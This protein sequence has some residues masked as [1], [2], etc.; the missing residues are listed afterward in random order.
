MHVEK[1]LGKS[2]IIIKG[3]EVLETRQQAQNGVA[4]AKLHPHVTKLTKL[5][6][7]LS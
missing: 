2:F 6:S 7:W 1:D 4:Y 3:K 5:Q